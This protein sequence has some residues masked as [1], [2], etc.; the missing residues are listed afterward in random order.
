MHVPLRNVL[1]SEL[2]GTFPYPVLP[3]PVVLCLPKS[4]VLP[5][6]VVW[7][8]PLPKASVPLPLVLC[9]LASAWF[10][11]SLNWLAKFQGSSFP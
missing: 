2:P 5:V 10:H 1:R 6:L 3:M 9:S 8:P 11:P 7:C 4:P